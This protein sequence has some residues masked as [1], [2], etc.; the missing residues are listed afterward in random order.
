MGKKYKLLLKLQ[1]PLARAV[2]NM[3]RVIP[4]R[5][6]IATGRFLGLMGY[7]VDSFHR[8]AAQIQMRTVLGDSYNPGLVRKVFMNH[9]DILVDA[10]KYA[11]MPVDEMAGLIDTE[12]KEH[13]DAAIAS[14]KGLMVITGHIGNWEI[15]T[16]VNRLF[17]A[18]FCVMADVRRDERL[19]SLV[20]EVR[21]RSGAII[22]PPKGKALML[23]RELKKGHTIAIVAD[24]RGK[25]SDGLFCDFFG[26]PAPTNPAPAFLALK[27]DALVMMT[28][29]VKINGRYLIHFS[30]A[31]EA[32]SFGTGK[33]GIANLSQFSQTWVESVVRKYP[34]QWFWLHCRWTR[35]SEMRRIIRKGL[36]FRNFVL[37][38]AHT[39]EN[40]LNPAD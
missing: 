4:Y 11:Y 34:D 5:Q 15:L 37:E 38:Q 9:G 10:I 18:E 20:N 39:E 30:E 14:K 36:D 26:L 25:R 23:L 33:E 12:G 7:Y 22:L 3:I 19:E 40:T 2:V 29:A 21:S 1:Y 6:A 28:Y 8:K 35:R 17:G 32:C 24:Q 27:S 16:H 31:R 13:F